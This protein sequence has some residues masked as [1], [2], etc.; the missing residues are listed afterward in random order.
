MCYC[1]P[2]KKAAQ[3]QLKALAASTQAVEAQLSGLRKENMGLADQMLDKDA[4]IFTLRSKVEAIHVE[5]EHQI[6]VERLQAQL[7]AEVKRRLSAENEA[8]DHLSRYERER[9]SHQNEMEQCHAQMLAVRE[10]LAATYQSFNEYKLRAQ[11]ILQV[12]LFIEI[13]FV[14]LYCATKWSI[15]ATRLPQ[16]T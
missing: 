16:T 1:S 11:R 6:K 8:K 12:S 10:E 7:D 14:F 15:V 3:Q 5:Q 9:S 4:E 13:L 2:D